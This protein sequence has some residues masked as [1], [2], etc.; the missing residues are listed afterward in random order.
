MWGQTENWFGGL[1]ENRIE[2]AEGR[3]FDLEPKSQVKPDLVIRAW[4]EVDGQ[5]TKGYERIVNFQRTEIP[6]AVKN[7]EG[8]KS[9]SR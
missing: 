6:K 2:W 4:V 8:V 1:D 3:D 5:P 7:S 9:A